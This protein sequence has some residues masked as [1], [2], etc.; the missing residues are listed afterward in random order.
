MNDKITKLAD[1]LKRASNEAMKLAET[2]DGGT[3]NLDSPV[4]KLPHWKDEDIAKAAELAGVSI[5]DKLSGLWNGYRFV[6]TS[7]RG[8]AARRTAMAEAAK[9]SLQSDGYDVHMYYAMD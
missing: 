8:Q 4:I 9:R 6:G 3:C 1:A 7:T 5:S 2:E